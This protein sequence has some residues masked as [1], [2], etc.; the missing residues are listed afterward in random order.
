MM[1]PF[2]LKREDDARF[3]VR[4]CRS[5]PISARSKTSRCRLPA[6]QDV[7]TK[8]QFFLLYIPVPGWAAM[9]RQKFLV[10]IKSRYFFHR[11]PLMR[12]NEWSVSF[13][14]RNYLFFQISRLSYTLGPPE[15]FC[16]FIIFLHSGAG[17]D[18]RLLQ[19]EWFCKLIILII[20]GWRKGQYRKCIVRFSR[21]H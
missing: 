9:C 16:S 20:A 13:H 3:T 12:S 15:P 21:R 17:D 19:H 4:S 5:G 7:N 1:R 14:S 18:C 8:L 6:V 10:L 11:M 2:G